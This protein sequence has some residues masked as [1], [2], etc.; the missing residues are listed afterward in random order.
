MTT[1]NFIE[2]NACSQSGVQFP[3]PIRSLFP[4]FSTCS[5]LFERFSFC[6]LSGFLLSILLVNCAM[7]NFRQL[8]FFSKIK[9]NFSSLRLYSHTS[10]LETVLENLVVK[11]CKPVILIYIYFPTYF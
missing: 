8:I 6:L 9:S 10:V 1:K 5:V 2:L 11:A 4:V 3:I 7:I